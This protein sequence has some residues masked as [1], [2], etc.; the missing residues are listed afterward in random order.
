M[1]LV[2]K[3]KWP[4]ATGGRTASLQ[5]KSCGNIRR[6]DPSA[7]K[8]IRPFLL[9]TRLRGGPLAGGL[10]LVVPPLLARAERAEPVFGYAAGEFT[11]DET[12]VATIVLLCTPRPVPVAWSPLGKDVGQVLRHHVRLIALAHLIT[13]QQEISL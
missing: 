11:V 9:P 3:G 12:H 2:T 7:Y 10:T 5:M 13:T 4:L 8:A 6:S 1:P